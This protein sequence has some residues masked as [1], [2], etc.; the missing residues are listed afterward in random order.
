MHS[1]L[2]PSGAWYNAGLALH[3]DL[4][5]SVGCACI[6]NQSVRPGVSGPAGKLGSWD[7]RDS[8]NLPGVGIDSCDSYLHSARSGR[9]SKRLWPFTTPITIFCGF[10]AHCVYL[11]RWPLARWIGY[12]PERQSN[13]ECESTFNRRYLN[14]PSNRS[15]DFR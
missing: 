11:L 15:R 3:H 5:F 4:R 8:A 7:R 13:D 2:W 10:I 14:N 1:Q 9:S 12:G 6:N